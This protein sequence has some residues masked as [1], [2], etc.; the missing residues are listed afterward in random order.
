MGE[1]ECQVRSGILCTPKQKQMWQGKSIS[2][3]LSINLNSLM[4]YLFSR[5]LKSKGLYLWL[6]VK[7]SW[8]QGLKKFSIA[9]CCFVAQL[10][11]LHRRHMLTG[12]CQH[13]GVSPLRCPKAFY[14]TVAQ[15]PPQADGDL[16]K[17]LKAGLRVCPAS[18]TR[19]PVSLGRFHPTPAPP[20][21]PGQGGCIFEE[22]SLFGQSAGLWASLPSLVTFVSFLRGEP[23]ALSS[24]SEEQ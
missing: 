17:E 11:S 23:S 13:T 14:K 16:N 9:L 4:W 10:L 6:S 2:N 22:S 8:G 7:S 3:S 1:R 15:L 5:K 24:V 21:T 18:L 20:W 12:D 19:G